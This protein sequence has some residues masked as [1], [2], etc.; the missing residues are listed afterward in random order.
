VLPSE[1]QLAGAFGVGRDAI[2][3]ALAVLVHEGLIQKGRG[4]LT[5]VRRPVAEAVVGIPG[6]AVV[7]ARM[8]NAEEQRQFNVSGGIPMLVVR[9][10]S[11]HVIYPADRVQLRP[12]TG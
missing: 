5:T 4:R 3:D 1:V 7:G 2:R 12:V 9:C 10:G 6:D 8:A 11:N